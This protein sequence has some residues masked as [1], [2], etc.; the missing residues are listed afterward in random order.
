MLAAV[1]RCKKRLRESVLVKTCFLTQIEWA[2]C[3]IVEV[4]H[5]YGVNGMGGFSLTEA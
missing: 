1:R 5:K 4:Y 3:P 2:V